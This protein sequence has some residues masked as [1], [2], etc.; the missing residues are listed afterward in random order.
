MA[1]PKGCSLTHSPRAA[2]RSSS[3]RVTPGAGLREATESSPRVRVPVLSKA[4]AR[5]WPA[6]SIAAGS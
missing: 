2:R 3:C 1:C 6:C 5:T 4:T